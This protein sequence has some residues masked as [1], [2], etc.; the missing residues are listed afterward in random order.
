MKRFCEKCGNQIKENEVFCSSCGNKINNS[1]GKVQNVVPNKKNG[2]STAGFICSIVGILTCGL[3]SIIGLI[4]SIIGFCQSKKKGEKDGLA[5]AG[6]II[7]AIIPCIGLLGVIIN[8]ATAKPVIVEDFSTMT[9]KEAEKICDEK[10]LNCYFTEEYSDTIPE[11][12]FV[13]Q[14][15][16]A[17]EKIMSYKSIDIVYSKG[18]KKDYSK[19]NTS[20]DT[21]SN[22]T[23]KEEAPQKTKEEI[24][25]EYIAACQVY[26]YKEIARQPDQYKGNKA[27]FRG[28]VI[29][30]SEGIINSKKVDLRINVTEGEYGLWD[31]TIYVKYTYKDGEPK[32]LED[33][34]V[35]IYGTIEGTTTYVSVLGSKITI[36][37]LKAEYIEIG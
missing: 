21:T 12:G 2:L 6:I 37:S 7:S 26:D 15:I 4:L 8:I 9:Q 11:G 19:N 34:I 31:D 32:V 14:S 35:N 27:R 25:A 17:G 28:K 18:V 29:Q 13:S 30:V 20:K 16:N 33:D 5:L 10:S 36:P 3:T 24:K 1:V 22:N 23:K